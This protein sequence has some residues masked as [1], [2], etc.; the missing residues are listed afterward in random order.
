MRRWLWPALAR[1]IGV[2]IVP[3]ARASHMDSEDRDGMCESRRVW[4]WVVRTRSNGVD[5][6]VGTF[7][8]RGACL[9]FE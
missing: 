9:R 5:S 6:D 2:A 1:T 8:C 4:A 3:V 7:P